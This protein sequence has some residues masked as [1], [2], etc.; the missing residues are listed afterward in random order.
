[1]TL[2]SG[3]PLTA[4]SVA[5]TTPPGR[6]EILATAAGSDQIAAVERWTKAAAERD[7]IHYF[8]ITEDERLVGQIFLHDI[9]RQKGECLV[10]YHLF[11]A[12]DRG[13]GTGSAA[14]ALLQSFVR[15]Q[16]DLRRMVAITTKWNQ[17][18]QGIARKCGFEFVGPP[19]ED[20]EEGMV[21]RY[22]VVR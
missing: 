13:R 22:E 12:S 17:G 2:Y 5:L 14:L 3:R 7:D 11:D 1:L 8:A 4:G 21:F 16:T 15:E 20:S 6:D 18:S 19:W 9:D 10:G